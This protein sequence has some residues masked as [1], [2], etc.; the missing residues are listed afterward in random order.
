VGAL[1]ARTHHS[2]SFLA[3]LL[4]SSNNRSPMS[5]SIFNVSRLHPAVRELGLAAATRGLREQKQP[6]K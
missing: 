2:A 4:H 5:T 3:E 6:M 1:D